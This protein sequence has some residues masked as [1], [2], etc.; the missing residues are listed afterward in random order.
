MPKQSGKTALLKPSRHH[1][2]ISKFYLEGFT[3]RGSKDDYLW[4]MDK[5]QKKQWKAKPENAAHQRDFYRVKIPGVEPDAVEKAF[6]KFENQAASIVERIIEKG[7][8]PKGEDFIIL[9]NFVA[10]M[11]VRIPRYRRVFDGPLEEMN[12]FILKL[13]TA[14][15]ERWETIKERMKRDGYEIDEKVSYEVMKCFVKRD[16]YSIKVS[17]EWHIQNLLQSIDIL[18]P[19]LLGRKW[20]LLIVK[21]EKDE[22]ICSDSPVA[23]VWTK[24]MPPFWGPGFGMKNTELTMPLNRHIGL[25]ASF[26]VEPQTLL[27]PKRA[28][29][30]LNSR[31]AMQAQ[32]FIYSNKQIFIWLK[33]SG[34]IGNTNDLLSAINTKKHKRRQPR[35]KKI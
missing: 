32:R 6:G 3:A 4:V 26:E 28:V 11:A 13:I 25:L 22:F 2:Y 20:S 16:K 14:N 31:T 24:P 33:R 34:E 7:A 35:E 5:E 12:K 19:L 27:A 21:D 30:K 18:I 29:A 10:L 15:P 23:L 9:I 1:H 17:R 8:L